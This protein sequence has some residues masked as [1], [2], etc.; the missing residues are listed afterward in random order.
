MRSLF[1]TWGDEFHFSIPVEAELDESVREQVQGGFRLL[2]PWEGL[3]PI[4]RS[5]SHEQ[6][7]EDHT[8]KCR[9]YHRKCGRSSQK[10]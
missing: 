1:N 7:A 10:V 9:Q 2:V 6:T 5:D 4:F 8:S 3:L